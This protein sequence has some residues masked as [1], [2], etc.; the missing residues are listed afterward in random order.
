M[1]HCLG[2]LEFSIELIEIL[3]F[4]RVY[5]FS[6]RKTLIILKN[7]LIFL[8]LSSYFKK[9]NIYITS[10]FV[11]KKTENFRQIKYFYEKVFIAFIHPLLF[12]F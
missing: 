1:F 6:A 8:L 11:V 7:P 2:N 5:R 10:Q 12:K 9:N 3:Y 4:I